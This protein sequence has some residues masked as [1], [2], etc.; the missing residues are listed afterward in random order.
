[1]KVISCSGSFV[2]VVA[3]LQA[4]MEAVDGRGAV[5]DEFAR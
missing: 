3:R 5:F 1:M 4:G 2:G